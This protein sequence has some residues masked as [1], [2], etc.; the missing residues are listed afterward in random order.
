MQRSSAQSAIG[1]GFMV[2]SIVAFFWWGLRFHVFGSKI[3]FDAAH[4]GFVFWLA[5]GLF[6]LS[7]AVGGWRAG[8][9]ATGGFGIMMILAV[10]IGILSGSY[11]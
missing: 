8:L 3:R 11:R 6:G 7:Y 10:G 5:L 9:K 4:L 2:F 1:L